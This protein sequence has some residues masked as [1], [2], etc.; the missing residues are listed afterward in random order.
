MKN[1]TGLIQGGAVISFVLSPSK[2]DRLG[3]TIKP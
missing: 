2:D 1:G 3:E